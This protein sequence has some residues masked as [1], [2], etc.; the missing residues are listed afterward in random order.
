M[1]LPLLGEMLGSHDIPDLGAN[2][3]EQLRQYAEL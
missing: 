2:A 1:A 3:S